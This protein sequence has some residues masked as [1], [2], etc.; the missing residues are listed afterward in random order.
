MG[1]A[2]DDAERRAD[3]EREEGMSDEVTTHQ[4]QGTCDGVMLKGDWSEY[5]I[6]IGKQ[7]PVKLATKH[8]DIKALAAAAGTQM[9]V[10]TYT[11]KQ[12]G[13]NP[14]R[15]GEFFKNRYLSNVEVGGTL[16]PALAVQ[17]TS[18]GSAA[19]AGATPNPEGRDTSIE[20]Q[21]IVK[22]AIGLYPG[23]LIETDDDWFAF[24]GRLDEWMAH[25]RARQGVEQNP[26]PAAAA[27]PAAAAPAVDPD[28]DI[29]F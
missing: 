11:E 27:T 23:T 26:A 9:A 19:R 4:I 1:D 14:H 29:P 15:P 25:E 20:R 17:Q 12:G 8:D 21:V 2:A 6:G 28:D 22:A 3:N 16:D 5:H 24:V 13:P 10:W 18:T 7:Y